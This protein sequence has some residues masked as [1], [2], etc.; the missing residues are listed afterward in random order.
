MMKDGIYIVYIA[1]LVA[2]FIKILIYANNSVCDNLSQNGH[3]NELFKVTKYG[4]SVQ[5]GRNFAGL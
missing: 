2:E 5:Q 3:K 4:I 1:F